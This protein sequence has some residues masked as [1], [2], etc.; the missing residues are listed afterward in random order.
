[1]PSERPS[2][3]SSTSSPSRGTPS[4]RPPQADQFVG[5]TIDNKYKINQLIARG[6]MGKV[7][8]A[9]QAPLG[10]VCAVKI[11]TIPADQ[12]ESGDFHK[13]FLLEASIGSKLTHPNT[14]T[15]FDYGVDNGTYYIAMEYL[16]GKTLAKLLKEEGVL[17]EERATHIARQICRSLREAHAMGVVHRDLKPANIYLVE[18]GDEADV[19]KVLDFGLVKNNEQEG[20]DL[21]QAGLFMGSPKYMSP[22]QIQGEHVDGRCD[23]YALGVL[24]YEMV[25]GHVPYERAKQLD[26]LLSH[27]NDPLPGLREKKA[28]LQISE[29]L[30]SVILK[31]LMKNPADRFTGMDEVLTTLKAAGRGSHT[32]TAELASLRAT[33]SFGPSSSQSGS[34]PSFTPPG[35][36]FR[37]SASGD[38]PAA[39]P[40]SIMPGNQP[41]APTKWVVLGLAAAGV[42]GAVLWFARSPPTP[43]AAA[44][45]PKSETK[46]ALTTPTAAI[47]A[48]PAP[49][50]KP[51]EAD[52]N[53]FVSVDSDPPGARVR[54]EAKSIVCDRTPCKV[55]LDTPTMNVVV[56]LE[57]HA[58]VKLKLSQGDG[59]AMAKLTKQTYKPATQA[60]PKPVDKPPTA[61]PPPTSFKNDPY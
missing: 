3:S 34:N 60:A 42:I 54:D 14:V 12:L 31:C 50:A 6:G 5:K 13:R 20:E 38:I 61:A 48:V 4:V 39:Q 51:V 40:A 27:V 9:E 32:G 45:P 47:A 55:H 30:E 57:G 11:L 44:G 46:S 16:E 8:K 21:T 35:N 37:P 33:G 41:K 19:V 26:T 59:Q 43:A 10:R 58:D 52:P 15:I 18:H 24:L 36:T 29:L 1:M 49:A 2:Q 53:T 22:E 56:D 25:T 28:D 17:D 7:Y 23:V